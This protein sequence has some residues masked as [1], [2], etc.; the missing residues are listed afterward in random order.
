MYVLNLDLFCPQMAEIARDYT[1]AR[2]FWDCQ[3]GGGDMLAA[4]VKM[5][6]MCVCVCVC[7]C[8]YMCVFMCMCVYVRVY[9]CVY[10][11]VYMCVS[12]CVC[13]CM[14]V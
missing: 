6:G 11:C 14:C 2:F 5:L 7:L 4:A 13:M 10:V 9:E 3:G 12:I 8:V 1:R